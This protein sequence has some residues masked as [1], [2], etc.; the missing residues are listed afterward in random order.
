M[1]RLKTNKTIEKIAS[2]GTG[3]ISDI[4]K[5]AYTNDKTGEVNYEAYYAELERIKN[6]DALNKLLEQH[7]SI[8]YTPKVGDWPVAPMPSDPLPNYPSIMN[9]GWICPKCGSVL[10]PHVSSCPNCSPATTINVTY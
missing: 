10:A 5:T 9:Y 2:E 7:P 8:L 6:N 4:L 1:N 3:N